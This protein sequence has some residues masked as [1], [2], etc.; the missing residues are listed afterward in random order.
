M[1]ERTMKLRLGAAVVLSIVIIIIFLTALGSREKFSISSYTIKIQLV[2]APNVVEYTPI[3]QS[4]ILIGRVSKVELISG[5]GVLVTARIF[6]DHKL[7]HDQ[8]CHLT[9]TLLGDASLRMI[10][11]PKDAEGYHPHTEIKPGELI[12]GQTMIDPTMLVAQMQEKLTVA[13]DDVTDAASVMTQVATTTNEMLEEN[14]AN[15]KDIMTNARNITSHSSTIVENFSK[16]LDDEFCTNIQTSVTNLREISENLPNTM[17]KVDQTLDDM[18]STIQLSNSTITSISER[19]GTTLD[20]VETLVGSMNSSVENIQK[21]TEP[22]ADENVTKKWI[23]N[24]TNILRNMDAFTE[25]LN[26]KDSTLGLLLYDRA[27]YDK[28]NQTMSLVS[29]LPRKLDPILFN[30]QVLTEKLAQHPEMLGL[31]GALKKDSG[32][33]QPIPWPKGISPYNGSYSGNYYTSSVYPNGNY[34]MSQPVITPS[35]TP[36]AKPA[37][38]PAAQPAVQPAA[39]SSAP[40][41]LQPQ[42]TSSCGKLK[43]AAPEGAEVLTPE[44]LGMTREEFQRANVQVLS[45]SVWSNQQTENPNEVV[46]PTLPPALPPIVAQPGPTT[47]MKAAEE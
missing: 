10:T 41:I 18:R 22:F 42:Q 40:S 33:S 43:P 23:A 32:T 38:Q 47:G 2:D 15:V 19:M 24:T 27:M 44:M 6:N 26:R 5:K 14:R 39:P 12:Y 28:M 35:T 9:S 16:I 1:N 20:S 4:G 13:I 21:I 29:D 8:E 30:A 17:S 7:Y 25:T 46:T 3:Y 31:R 34:Y 11:L 36:A 45:D 37:A